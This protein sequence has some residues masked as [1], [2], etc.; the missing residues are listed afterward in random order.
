MIPA[1]SFTE[2]SLERKKNKRSNQDNGKQKEALLHDT[3]SHNVSVIFQNPSYSDP[4]K[5][6]IDI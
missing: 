3:A 4:E 2:M 6:L 5:S 1:K